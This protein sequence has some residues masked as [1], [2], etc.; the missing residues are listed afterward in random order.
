MR[1]NKYHH[2][3]T[4]M[5]GKKKGKNVMKNLPHEKKIKELEKC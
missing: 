2:Y 4:Q 1:G 5:K 3:V